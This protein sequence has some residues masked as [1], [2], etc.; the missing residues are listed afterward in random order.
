MSKE[1]PPEQMPASAN[2]VVLP[3]NED[4]A[5]NITFPVPIPAKRNMSTAI[6]QVITTTKTLRRFCGFVLS[7]CG[8][9]FYC[10]RVIGLVAWLGYNYYRGNECD[11]LVSGL[12]SVADGLGIGL[13]FRI[14]KYPH[15][16]LESH[17]FKVKLVSL[18]IFIISL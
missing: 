14:M 2:N 17:N 4:N 18:L 10:F 1:A 12:E 5:I 11:W 8:L 13:F 9:L 16:T 7:L 3:M 6:P 15:L